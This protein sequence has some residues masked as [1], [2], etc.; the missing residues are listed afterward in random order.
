MLVSAPLR[1]S[2]SKM[3]FF[4]GHVVLGSFLFCPLL[5]FPD[6]HHLF[7][8]SDFIVGVT[9]LLVRSSIFRHLE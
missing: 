5:V 1:F 3:E 9:L 4:P 7:A 8:A 6:V 2:D